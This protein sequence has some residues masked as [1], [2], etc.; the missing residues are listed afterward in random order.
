MHGKVPIPKAQRPT[1]YSGIKVAPTFN[2]L[3]KKLRGK[4]G[5]PI[6]P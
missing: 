1:L 4:K 5:V 3:G 6:K 2:N